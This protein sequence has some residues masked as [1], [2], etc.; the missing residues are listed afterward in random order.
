MIDDRVNFKFCANV[1]AA[2]RF[3]QNKHIGVGENP[4]A[5]ADF[6][7]VTAGEVARKLRNGGRFDVKLVAVFLRHLNFLQNLQHLNLH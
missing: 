7:L 3:V 4:T 5:E 1:D 6:L 2:R